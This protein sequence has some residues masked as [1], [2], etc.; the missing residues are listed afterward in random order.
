MD[1]VRVLVGVRLLPFR[2]FRDGAFGNTAPPSGS[3]D[4]N[5]TAVAFLADVMYANME[6]RRSGNGMI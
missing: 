3:T 5:I 1:Q 2:G 4:R 6:R